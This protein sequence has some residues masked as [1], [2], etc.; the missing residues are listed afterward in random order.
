MK[1]IISGFFSQ[2]KRQVLMS[3]TDLLVALIIILIGCAGFGL[4]RLSAV[5]GGKTRVEVIQGTVPGE[6]TQAAAGAEAG[7]YVASKSGSKYHLPWCSGAQR[8]NDENKIWFASHEEAR[9]AGYA[10]AENCPGL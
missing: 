8:I 2:I 1:A 9:R 7:M 5:E 4:G 3:P 6:Q 10:P